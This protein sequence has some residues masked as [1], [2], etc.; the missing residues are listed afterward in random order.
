MKLYQYTITVI[1]NYYHLFHIWWNITSVF[2]FCNFT[3]ACSVKEIFFTWHIIYS[4]FNIEISVFF[5]QSVYSKTLQTLP[6]VV[7]KKP[8]HPICLVPSV[9]LLFLSPLWYC[10]DS[11]TYDV[12]Y[13]ICTSRPSKQFCHPILHILHV[14]V[15]LKTLFLSTCSVLAY[16]EFQVIRIWLSHVIWKH[17]IAYI[18]IFIWVH[19]FI[20][21]WF[22]LGKQKLPKSQCE[23]EQNSIRHWNQYT[24]KCQDKHF[25][26]FSGN[27]KSWYQIYYAPSNLLGLRTVYWSDRGDC[28]WK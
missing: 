10:L 24:V 16:V 18:Q 17:Q 6:Q 13:T 22:K 21:G 20:T 23:P 5:Q 4:N 1:V 8:L 25:R 3:S 7:L 11:F 28:S 15:G 14:V 27:V 19:V 9:T 2:F 26:L 12:C